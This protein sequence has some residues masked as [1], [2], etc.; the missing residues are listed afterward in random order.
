MFD[1][2]IDKLRSEV[3]YAR[4][5]RE[6][7]LRVFEEQVAAYHTPFYRGEGMV[8]DYNPENHAYQLI[9]ETVPQMVYKNPRVRTD[10]AKLGLGKSVAI[11]YKHL[12]N[13][14]IKELD[15]ESL[16][17]EHAHDVLFQFTVGMVVPRR[18]YRYD[19]EA[20][21][22]CIERVPQKCFLIDPTA[23]RRSEARWMGHEWYIDKN[24]LIR[25]AQDEEGWN[26]DAVRGLATD[27]ESTE[28]PKREEVRCVDMW[29]RDG[30]T[31]VDADADE[32]FH[33]ARVVMGWTEESAGEI[34]YGPEPAFCNVNG[35]YRICDISYVPDSPFGLSPLVATEGQSRELNKL[36][37]RAIA[38]SMRYARLLLVEDGDDAF[39]QRLKD[40][41]NDLVLAVRSL[42]GNKVQSVERGGITEQIMAQIQGAK[43]RL[44][45]NSSMSDARRGLAQKNATATAESIAN[46]ASDIRTG[47]IKSRFEIFVRGLLDDIGYYYWYDKRTR[48]FLG[49]SFMADIGFPEDQ[50]EMTDFPGFEYRGGDAFFK[51]YKGIKY[52]DIEIGIEPFSMGYMS[53]DMMQKRAIDGLTIGLQIAQAAATLPGPDYAGLANIV[54]DALNMPDFAKHLGLSSIRA[55]TALQQQLAPQQPQQGTG[56]LGNESGGELAAAVRG[57]A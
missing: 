24:D 29:F 38:M 53:P 42:E 15:L 9:T 5:R 8:G 19:E 28:G 18:D 6:H 41:E 26:V 49:G 22:P 33:G 1:L 23:K 56:M 25:L 27:G 39:A 55:N 14:R 35:P 7:Q 12:L 48:S 17:I 2:S 45:R 10:T 40:A 16:L 36:T 46:A 11:V 37:R 54:G 52:E 47:F 20:W 34:L 32:G 43:E 57:G 21:N 13:R 50:L 30:E 3:R 44:D 4:T 51:P 31:D